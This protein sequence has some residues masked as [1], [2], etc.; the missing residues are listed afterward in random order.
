MTHTR[1]FILAFCLTLIFSCGNDS[2]NKEAV[3]AIE[4]PQALQES[5]EYDISK[6]RSSRSDLVTELYNE[7]VE[8]DSALKTLEGELEKIHEHPKEMNELTGFLQK[9]RQY[10]N[11]AGNLA[12]DI[13]DSVLRKRMIDMIRKSSKKDSLASVSFDMLLE[14]V[15]RNSISISDY[16]NVLMIIKTMPLI[17]DYQKN[18]I[19]SALPWQKYAKAQED[20]IK[21][22]KGYE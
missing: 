19:P 6:I 3:T 1:F 2:V 16:H 18:H 5:S 17:E 22:M 9:S 10:Y 15:G 4:T 11:S 12:H 8:K 13:T 14:R 20:L 7:I 21:N